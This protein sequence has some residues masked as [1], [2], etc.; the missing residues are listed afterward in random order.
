MAVSGAGTGGEGGGEAVQ[1]GQEGAQEAQ[2]QQAPAIPPELAQRLDALEGVPE[3][4][5]ELR[6]A[7]SM[8]DADPGDGGLQQQAEPEVLMDPRTGQMFDARTGEPIDVDA[9]LGPELSAEQISD[10]VESRAREIAQEAVAPLQAQQHAAQ[11]AALEETYPQMRDHDVAQRVVAEARELAAE[12]GNPEA[13]R[14][15]KLLENVYLAQR[16]RERAEEEDELPPTGDAETLEDPGAVAAAGQS[17]SDVGDAI[18]AA[19]GGR[20]FWMGG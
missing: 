3:A 5:A 18:V 17:E 6:E 4:I 15:P 8:S 11:L 14:S 16:A 9:G 2:Q 12:Y 13:W 19:G 1:G 10:L 20:S 7:L